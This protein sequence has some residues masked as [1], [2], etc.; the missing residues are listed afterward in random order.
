MQLR[1]TESRGHYSDHFQCCRNST[2]GIPKEEEVQKKNVGGIVLPDEG[3][4]YCEQCPVRRSWL[5]L[6]SVL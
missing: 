2:E 4:Q 6:D 1:T 5:P 3:G